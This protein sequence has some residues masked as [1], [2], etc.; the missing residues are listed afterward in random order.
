M[1]KRKAA[2]AGQE[3]LLAALSSRLAAS[4][5]QFFFGQQENQTYLLDL[6]RRTVD[7]E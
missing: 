5:D 1:V 6:L 3:E 7:K 4:Q 2:M